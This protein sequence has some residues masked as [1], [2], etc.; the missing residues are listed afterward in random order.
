MKNF[1]KETSDN[2]YVMVDDNPVISEDNS[3]GEKISNDNQTLNLLDEIS[4]LK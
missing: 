2:T 3:N 4:I 1:P